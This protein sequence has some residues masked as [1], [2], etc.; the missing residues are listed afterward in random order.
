MDASGAVVAFSH[1]IPVPNN[2][3]SFELVRIYALPQTHGTGVGTTL[4]NQLFESL[5]DFSQLSAWV[6]KDNPIGRRFYERHGFQAV[7]E[8]D[9]EILGHKTQLMKYVVTPN[10]E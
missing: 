2:E 1:T 3:G 8:K 5:K 6:E 10:L 7:E 9:D 4:L